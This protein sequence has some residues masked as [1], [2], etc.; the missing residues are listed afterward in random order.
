VGR[1][2]VAASVDFKRLL[3]GLIEKG[4]TDISLDLSECLLMDSTFLGVLAGFG[5][6]LGG[7]QNGDAKGHPIELLDP[8]ARVEELL[9]NLGMIHLFKVSHGKAA[10]DA[11]L[12]SEMSK[13]G[14]ASKE[15]VT[16]NC[17]EAHRKLMELNP[18]NVS[19]FK[20]VTQYLAEN[21]KKIKV[22][23]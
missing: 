2:N 12:N 15:E 9:D 21:L 18:D 6:K 3:N 20:D 4:V 19:R 23:K 22:S 11:K 16:R 1:A 5:Q 17:L 14:A 7:A 8:N 13:P 10:P